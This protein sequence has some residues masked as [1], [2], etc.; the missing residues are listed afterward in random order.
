MA[1]QKKQLNLNHYNCTQIA[2]YNHL[3]F[4]KIIVARLRATHMTKR[5]KT[6]PK[7]ILSLEENMPISEVS[8]DSYDYK[9]FKNGKWTLEEDE[10]LRK[11]VEVFGEKK[12]KEISTMVLGRSPLQC[13]HRWTKILRPGLIKGAWTPQENEL[14]REWVRVNGPQRWS[15]CATIIV[16]RSGKQCREHWFNKLSPDI[17]KGNW[18]AEEDEKIFSLYQQFGT[19]WSKIEKFMPGRTENSIKN[20]FY[21]TLRRIDP[22]SG[23][24]KVKKESKQD[25][26]NQGEFEGVCSEKTEAAENSNRSSHKRKNSS[27]EKSKTQAPTLAVTHMKNKFVKAV[28]ENQST[29]TKDEAGFLMKAEESLT[30]DYLENELKGETES[31]Q[32][33]GHMNELEQK[34][35]KL[36]SNQ[37]RGLNSDIIDQST[38]ISIVGQSPSSFS[39]PRNLPI[40]ALTTDLGAFELYPMMSSHLSQN[41]E[42]QNSI[43]WMYEII[44]HIT[45]NTNFSNEQ[46][47]IFLFQQLKK[48]EEMLTLT[49]TEFLMRF[50]EA[51]MHTKAQEDFVAGNEFSFFESFHLLPHD[52]SNNTT[53]F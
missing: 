21:S 36:G 18:T 2:N 17:K 28:L 7:T 42:M 30:N 1:I 20:R 49:K 12:W 48:L 8:S 19:R 31:Q 45:D 27:S 41:D 33:L 11:G 52:Y 23:A 44:H 14:L 50:N 3:Q 35:V 46:K 6:I 51:I 13:L 38:S 34:L 16:G 5:Q 10:Q 53:S 43:T 40:T 24:K 29:T 4:Q 37:L 25:S 47:I 26:A 32:L 15:E 22:T 39:D 9:N